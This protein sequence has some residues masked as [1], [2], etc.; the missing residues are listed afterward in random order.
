M[1]AFCK[2]LCHKLQRIRESPDG[3]NSNA[4]R[5]FTPKIQALFS[6]ED[7]GCSAED[8]PACPAT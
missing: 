3:P 1:D 4:S 6:P 7:W 2:Q 5:F 8:H